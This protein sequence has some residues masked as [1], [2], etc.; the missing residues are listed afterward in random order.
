MKYIFKVLIILLLFSCEENI[1]ENENPFIGTWNYSTFEMK[2]DITTN[3]DQTTTPMMGALSGLVPMTNGLIIGGDGNNDTLNYMSLF[4]GIMNMDFME[5]STL[6]EEN[7]DESADL[8]ESLCMLNLMMSSDYDNDDE[9]DY[10]VMCGGSYYMGNLPD[11]SINESDELLIEVPLIAINESV[12]FYH[13][14]IDS[15]DSDTFVLNTSDNSRTITLSGSV[16]FPEIIVNADTPTDLMKI[17]LGVSL[18]EFYELQ[19]FDNNEIVAEEMGDIQTIIINSDNTITLH[20]ALDIDEDMQITALDTCTTSWSQNGDELTILEESITCTNDYDEDGDNNLSL[21][22]DCACWSAIGY[23]GEELC[24]SGQLTSE[25][26]CLSAGSCDWDCD[27]DDDDDDDEMMPTISIN[28]DGSLTLGFTTNSYCEFIESSDF[29]MI[30]YDY[31]IIDTEDE[32]KAALEKS[33]LFDEGSIKS[34][35][36]GMLAIYTNATNA[37]N[38]V[39]NFPNGHDLKKQTEIVSN[40][41]KN[42]I[43]QTN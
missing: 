32:C 38:R 6:M 26:S 42:F 22:S 27:D 28:S 16:G 9:T 13:V 35:E 31:D 40:W 25:E 30:D 34:I 12:M 4:I 24:E 21:N 19:G 15:I 41:L 14:N 10:L 3:S 37:T 23:E 5:L 36:M 11:G 39:N 7:D 1:S 33:L 18:E 8:P 29:T 43:P 17:Q 20:I 2:Q